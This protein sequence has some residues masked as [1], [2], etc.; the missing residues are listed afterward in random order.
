[1]SLAL[2]LSQIPAA[3]YILFVIGLVLAAVEFFTPG[4]GLFG[5]S[6]I[7]SFLAS[8]VVV[9]AAAGSV[10]AGLI[11]ALVVLLVLAALIV[12]FSVFASR[13][14]FLR[15]L[16]LPDQLGA[17]EGFSSSR[18]YSFLSG[19]TG[20]SETILRPAGRVKIEGESYDA[21]TGGE[22]IPAETRIRVAS[23]E[24]SRIVVREAPA[25]EQ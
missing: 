14:R 17:G 1:M 5:I 10:T 15:P 22:F 12:L 11:F 9:T 13:G 21:V 4:F 18:D 20:T 8:I 6:A 3:A 25:D 16:T 7:V 24:G 23:V 19:K 2:I